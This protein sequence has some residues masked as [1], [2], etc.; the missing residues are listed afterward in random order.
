M[1]SDLNP[2]IPCTSFHESSQISRI[3]TLDNL[4]EFIQTS[5]GDE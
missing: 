4:P 1:I 3:R 5:Y 2:G